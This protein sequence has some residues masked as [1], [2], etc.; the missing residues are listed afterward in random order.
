MVPGPSITS[1]LPP[2][3]SY[4]IRPLP[5]LLPPL[6]D[7]YLTL[8]LPVLAYWIVSLVFHYIDTKDLFSQYR[9]HTPAEILKRNHVSRWDVARDVIVQQVVQTL[10][11][12]VLTLG[13]LPQMAGKDEYNVTIWA[14]RIRI[15]QRMIPSVLSTFGLNAVEWAQK[16]ST[17]FPTLA[18]ALLGG[19]YPWITKLD[20]NGPFPD[21]ASWEVLVAKAI[22][23]FIIPAFQFGLAICIV[24]TWQ[25]FLHRAMHMNKWL[26]SESRLSTRIG[27]C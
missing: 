22:Y 7:K 3:P 16:L 25:Y 12:V 5:P 8:V 17:S 4:T 1:D 27:R 21:F 15:T 10:V 6:E 23:W 18:G 11:G 26:Y 24:D 13:D 14:Q 2:L 9:L 20:D 19:Q